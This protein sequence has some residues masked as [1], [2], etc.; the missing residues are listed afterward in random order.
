LYGRTGNDTLSGGAG[1]DALYGDED[2]DTCDI[3][4]DGYLAV[5]CEA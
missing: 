1:F 2:F 5:N 3:G 4:P